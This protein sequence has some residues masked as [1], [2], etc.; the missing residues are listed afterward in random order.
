MAKKDAVVFQVEYFERGGLLQKQPLSVACK[1]SCVSSGMNGHTMLEA[2]DFGH[3]RELG[4]QNI[5]IDSRQMAFL[6]NAKLAH[7]FNC[8]GVLYVDLE[9]DRINLL[10]KNKFPSIS[11][12]R[13]VDT[14]NHVPKIIYTI[15]DDE[16]KPAR[17]LI[18]ADKVRTVADLYFTI[19]KASAITIKNKRAQGRNYGV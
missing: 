16:R 18:S 19:I 13:T 6:Q 10:C 3:D 1:S 17:D 9:L 14:D 8:F 11:V 2:E 5:I 12:T 4:R 7:T 15:Q